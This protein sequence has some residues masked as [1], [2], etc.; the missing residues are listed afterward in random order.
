[1]EFERFGFGGGT[2]A[3]TLKS[4]GLDSGPVV[5]DVYT[6]LKMIVYLCKRL[7]V[8]DFEFL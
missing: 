8:V 2:L 5:F 7:M 3:I 4:S 1:M 6:S